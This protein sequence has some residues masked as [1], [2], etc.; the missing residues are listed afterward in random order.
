MLADDKTT[1]FEVLR[2]EREE[3]IATRM[4]MLKSLP[5]TKFNVGDKVRFTWD[6]SEVVGVVEIVDFGGSL[7]H[8]YHSYDIFADDCLYKHIPEEDCRIVC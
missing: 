8:D 3:E 7:E 4:V 2:K 6:G 5:P 1:G